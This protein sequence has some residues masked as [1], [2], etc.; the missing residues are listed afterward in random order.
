MC[1]RINIQCKEFLQT[2]HTG[3]CPRF[4]E[5]LIHVSCHNK[6]RSCCGRAE[7]PFPYGGELS[8]GCVLGRP[9]FQLC[10]ICNYPSTLLLMFA[11][12][13]VSGSVQRRTTCACTACWTG[14]RAPTFQTL[15]QS[16]FL[17]SS[18]GDNQYQRNQVPL[19]VGIVVACAICTTRRGCLIESLRLLF[20]KSKFLNLE[21]LS[22]ISLSLSL[23]VSLF[24]QYTVNLTHILL[25]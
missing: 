19:W 25:S 13:D 12:P 20:K 1:K 18:Y 16:E 3:L 4:H 22:C 17:P 21:L 5:L 14:S 8:T 6:H 11:V 9:R 23:S 15:W 24:S 2:R 7:F 10:L